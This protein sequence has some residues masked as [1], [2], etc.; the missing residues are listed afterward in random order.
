MTMP[1]PRRTPGAQGPASDAAES[2]DWEPF[3]VPSRDLV[4][5]AESGW[6]KFLRRSEAGEEAEE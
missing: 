3:G 4:A 1:L 5:R 2:P 6:E